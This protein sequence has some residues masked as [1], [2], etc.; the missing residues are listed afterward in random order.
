MSI[1]KDFAT[2]IISEYARTLYN[3]VGLG[4]ARSQGHV[5]GRS[6]FTLMKKEGLKVEKLDVMIEEIREILAGKYKVLCDVRVKRKD[7]YTV[8]VKVEGC[9]MHPVSEMLKDVGAEVFTCPITGL[10]MAA[11]EELFDVETEY[12]KFS[13]SDDRC[14]IVFGIC[15]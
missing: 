14:R 15:E 10:I 6:L 2:S 4:H 12:R 9:V 1:H 8:V 7:E 11:V 13:I 3:I 5:I